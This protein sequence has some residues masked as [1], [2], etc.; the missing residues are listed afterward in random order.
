MS[1]H[2]QSEDLDLEG[3]DADAV[4]GGRMS[5]IHA[6]P[7]QLSKLLKE[8]FAE[9]ECLTDGSTLLVN[10]HTGQRAIVSGPQR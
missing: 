3:A 1:Q 5:T 8:G 6:H 9:K 4:V 2:E 10:S 7:S